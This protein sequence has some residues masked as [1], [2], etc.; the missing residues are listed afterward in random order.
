MKLLKQISIG[1]SLALMLT[2]NVIANTYVVKSGDTLNSIIERLG[3]KSIA[4]SGLKAPSGD[5]NL[6]F[7]GDRL[8]YKAKHKKK[9]SRFKSKEVIDLKKFCFKSNR[10]IHYRANERCK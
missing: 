1:T 9:K 6:I 8:E 5:M 3:F 10:S 4:E 7:P 2:T